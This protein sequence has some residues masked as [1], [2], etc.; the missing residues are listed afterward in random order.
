[1]NFLVL[2]LLFFLIPTNN[3]SDT[4]T[5][6]LPQG[7][8]WRYV[9]DELEPAARFGE[10]WRSGI[11]LEDKIIVLNTH[12]LIALD[13]NGKELWKRGLPVEGTLAKAKILQ[14]AS[15]EIL[16]IITSAIL[17]INTDNGELLHHYGYNTHKRSAFQFTEL[18]PRTAILFQE[19]L[20]VF[21][22][23]EL[24]S[25]H[26][27]TLEKNI[28][29]NFNSSPK[30]LPVLFNNK[31]IIGF[32]NGF[33]EMFDPLTKD[34]KTLIYGHKH[35][36]FSV[37]QII[38]KDDLIY[39]P[40]SHILQVFSNDQFYAK[41]DQFPDNILS[42]VEGN[43]WLRQH[44]RGNLIHIDETL[45]PLDK[46]HFISDR[47]ANKISSP[48]IGHNGTLIQVDSI[49]GQIFVIQNKNVKSII[50]AEDFLD[51][52]PIQILAQNKQQLL[53]GGFDGLYLID[54]NAL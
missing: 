18:I 38:T 2:F 47:I 40:S 48:L 34:K 3:F 22:G 54:I 33:V 4:R 42:E 29:Y 26:K 36:N 16:V 32:L 19:H 53:L 35:Q 27:D 5:D 50:Y 12:T 8:K 24:L 9:M 7:F 14:S 15:N 52:P 17:K 11:L 41:S 10:F 45:S 6:N 31:F 21:L 13:H 51:N 37:R 46:I 20:F 23:P 39:I 25:F 49:E 30:T 44:N 43:I 1:M 28:V